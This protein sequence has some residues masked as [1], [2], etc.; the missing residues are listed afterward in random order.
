MSHVDSLPPY[1]T[2]GTYLVGPDEGQLSARY[3]ELPPPALN[4]G[5]YTGEPFAK[6]ASWRNFPVR[7]ETVNVIYNN[8]RSMNIPPEEALY[9]FPGGGIRPGNNMPELPLEYVNTLR[10]SHTNEMCIP[11]SASKLLPTPKRPPLFSGN[12]Y[13]QF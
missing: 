13:L 10:Y 5:L 9:L 1:P 12:V 4:G 3:S 6:N 7:P 8:L 2:S 11:R